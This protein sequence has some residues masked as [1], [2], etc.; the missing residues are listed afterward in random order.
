M[1]KTLTAGQRA[2]VRLLRDGAGSPRYFSRID[3]ER[4]GMLPEFKAA[5]LAGLIQ[6]A[7][8]ECSIAGDAFIDSA[9]GHAALFSLKVRAASDQ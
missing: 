1:S 4:K 6:S 3:A 2:L 9:E 7:G 5:L 8:Y